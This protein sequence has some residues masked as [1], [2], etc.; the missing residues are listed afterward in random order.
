M[1]PGNAVYNVPSALEITGDLGLDVLEQA[2]NQIV[3]RHEILRT[4]FI[5]AGSDPMQVVWERMPV[6]FKVEDAPDE[7]IQERIT[8]E[9]RRPF[10]LESGPLLRVLVLRCPDK[11]HVLVLTMHHIVFD[12]WSRGI[13]LREIVAA[14]GSLL[15]GG[16]VHLDPVSIQYADYAVWQRKRL[17]G[18]ALQRLVSFWKT[19]LK[20]MP[21]TL[22]LPADRAKPMVRNYAGDGVGFTI[23]DPLAAQVRALASSQGVT[24]FMLVLSAFATLLHRYSCQEEVV[25]GTPIAGRGRREVESLIIHRLWNC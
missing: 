8:I 13:F 21:E 22:E 18:D 19:A 3:Q 17:Q 20:G 9:V 11:R 12:E 23:P 1:E 24:M 14:Y 2:M 16:T 15:N 7:N 25:I 10:S 4:T 5:L 6:A